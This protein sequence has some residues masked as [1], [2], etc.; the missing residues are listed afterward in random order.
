MRSVSLTLLGS[1]FLTI[2]VPVW[3]LA[4]AG[5]NSPEQAVEPTS[6]DPSAEGQGGLEDIVVTAQRREQALQTVPIAIQAFSQKALQSSGIENTADLALVTPGLVVVRGVG[7]SSPFLRGIGSS[8]NG[9][10]VESPIATYVDGVYYGSKANAMMSLENIER[11]EVLKGPQGTLFGRNATGGLIQVIT[12]DP[13][14]TPGFTAKVGYQNYNTV[15][16]SGYVTGGLAEGVSADFAVNY[17]NQG[18]GWGYNTVTGVDVNV[19][20]GYVM[21]GKLLFE[22]SDSTRIMLAGDYS[23]SDSD[24]GLATRF[25]DGFLGNNG[26]PYVGPR[27]GLQATFDQYFRSR[28]R[29]ASLTVTHDFNDITLTSI[30]AYRRTNY[31]FAFDGDGTPSPI[32]RFETAVR[33]RQFSQE[34]QLSGGSRGSLEW[35]AGAYYFD[36][37]GNQSIFFSGTSF[38][39]LITRA[40]FGGQTTRSYAGYAQATYPILDS[41]RITLGARYN[42]EKRGLSGN[43][44]LTALNGTVTTPT[45]VPAGTDTTFNKLTW[46]IAVDH[47]LSEDVMGYASYNRGFRS[48]GYNPSNLT[49]PPFRPE[50]LDAYELGL[51]SSLFDRRV[52]FNVAAF[53]NDFQDIQLSQFVLGVQTVRN[54]ASAETYGVDVDFEALVATRLRLSGSMEYLKGKYKSFPGAAFAVPLP[55]GGNAVVIGDAAGKDVVRTPR[56]TANAAV[57]YSMPLGS[58]LSADFNV[59]YAYN[60][61]FFWEPDNLLF[62]KSYSLVNA[63][64]SLNFNDRHKITIWGRNLTDKYYASTSSAASVGTVASPAEP[65]TYGITLETKF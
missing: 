61:G 25:A 57:D 58:D 15:T 10:G 16:A 65:R 54:A 3:A 20:D 22:P 32:L 14:S 45:V 46:R 33:E 12:R 21:R 18:K 63:R 60:D 31:G 17:R 5:P 59:T 51:K 48:G 30:T 24:T 35:T 1:T 8:S 43:V 7:L 62:Q 53:Y 52:R 29:G 49:N 11:V 27:Y 44:Q 41:T 2:S 47:D 37:N 40:V 50:V 6:G 55:G 42:S 13:S 26:L 39:T 4:Q 56:W 19:S 64:A 28:A 23:K 9:P 36:G 38:P 34:L